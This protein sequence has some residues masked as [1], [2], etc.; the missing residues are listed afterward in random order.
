VSNTF[1]IAS[2]SYVVG[3]PTST[4]SGWLAMAMDD[5]AA[6]GI[7][8]SAI[9]KLTRGVF[10]SVC[11]KMF[12]CKHVAWLPGLQEA[13]FVG[14]NG[15]CAVVASD[16]SDRDEYVT[17]SQ[18][19]PRNT[20]HIRAAAKLGNDVIVVGMQRQAYRRLGSG[21]WVDM[22]RGIPSAAG[23][24]TSGFECVLALSETEIYAAGWR[25][26]LW[27]FEGED[28]RRLDSP[29]NR[30]ITSLGLNPNGEVFACGRNGLLI[31]GRK[32][33]WRLIS[34]SACP[35]D[36]WALAAGSGVQFAAALR[37]LYTLNDDGTATV[38]PLD[39]LGAESFGYLASTSDVVW[40]LGEKDFLSFDGARWSRIG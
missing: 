24:E 9:L 31:A 17:R 22:N 40:S 2:S 39:E 7:E 11:L 33:T 36:L 21:Q 26:E 13:V 27:L 37:R 6:Q 1:N 19:S 23:A 5:V 38:V 34:D 29:T 8:H 18:R 20:G 25:G 10:E 16:G 30:I 4:T 12:R 14:D 3:T 35:D 32:D 28:W 15:E